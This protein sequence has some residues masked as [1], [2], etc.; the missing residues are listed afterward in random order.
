MTKVEAITEAC[1]IIALAFHS[2]G[3]YTHSS[4]GFC[5]R[6]QCMPSMYGKDYRNDGKAIEYVRQAV[7]AKLKADGFKIAETFDSDTGRCI[8]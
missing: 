2:I 6:C 7:L 8:V 4:D 1:E 5:P 3:D